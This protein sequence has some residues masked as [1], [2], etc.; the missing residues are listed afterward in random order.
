MLFI[1]C[2]ILSLFVQVV[3]INL[4]SWVLK[5]IDSISIPFLPLAIP[6]CMC[7]LDSSDMHVCLFVVLSFV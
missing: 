2:Y 4:L 3:V 1:V 5:W 6:S 7:C